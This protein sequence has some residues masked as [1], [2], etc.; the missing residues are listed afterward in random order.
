MDVMGEGTGPFCPAGTSHRFLGFR[1]ERYSGIALTLHDFVYNLPDVYRPNHHTCIDPE[2]DMTT[3]N[4]RIE[5]PRIVD[6]TANVPAAPLVLID[7]EEGATFANTRGAGAFWRFD[8]GRKYLDNKKQTVYEAPVSSNSPAMRFALGMREPNSTMHR[9]GIAYSTI[10]TN[11]HPR[12]FS[13]QQHAEFWDS[14]IY[15]YDEA[16]KSP[17]VLDTLIGGYFN[18]RP[19]MGSAGEYEEVVVPILPVP[20]PLPISLPLPLVHG[21]DIAQDLLP[22]NHHQLR[23]AG[24][25]LGGNIRIKCG[26]KLGTKKE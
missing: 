24:R 25:A 14:R 17:A 8:I 18:W 5:L 21:H 4:I 9:T 13:F 23:C 16:V 26:S 12:H 3:G 15:A 6:G 7:P 1:N 11:G 22:I 2:D 20:S 19:F 10:V